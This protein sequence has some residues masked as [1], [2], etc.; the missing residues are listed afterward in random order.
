MNWQHLAHEDI[1]IQIG[2]KLRSM[3]KTNGYSQV[4]LAKLT[5]LGRT[6]IFRI[7]KGEA[8]SMDAVVRIMRV[9]HILDR[10][11]PLFESPKKSPMQSF[12]DGSK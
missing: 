1:F 11:N 6:T 4:E 3:R 8:I 5:G 9:Y 7:E 12:L 2:M 10:F